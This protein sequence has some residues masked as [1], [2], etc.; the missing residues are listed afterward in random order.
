MTLLMVSRDYRSKT[1]KELEKVDR[2][3]LLTYYQ[4]KI[5]D[6]GLKIDLFDYEIRRIVSQNS[7][8]EEKEIGDSKNSLGN[9]TLIKIKDDHPLLSW[10][11][12]RLI[13]KSLG[14]NCLINWLEERNWTEIEDINNLIEERKKYLIEDFKRL[15]IFEAD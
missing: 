3:I 5:K 10:T 6:K 13:Y 12:K 11:E 14:D 7:E 8:I 9:L 15:R 4:K 2:F 1:D